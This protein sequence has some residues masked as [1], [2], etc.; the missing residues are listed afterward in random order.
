MKRY[1]GIDYG[2]AR[3]GLA[4]GDDETRVASPLRIVKTLGEAAELIREEGVDCLVIG[5][6]SAIEGDKG[7]MPKKVERFAAELSRKCGLPYKLV[8]ERFTSK[9]AED[10]LRPEKGR[11]D[12]DAVAAMLILQSYFDRL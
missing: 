9:I 8:D 2:A 6:P 5:V 10:L 1:I 12:E 7:D 4:L 11:P 3:I